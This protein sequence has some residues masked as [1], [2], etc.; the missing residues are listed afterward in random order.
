MLFWGRGGHGSPFGAVLILGFVVLLGLDLVRIV[1]LAAPQ[2][3]RGNGS[4]RVAE[5]ISWLRGGD[6]ETR[7]HCARC[8]ECSEESVEVLFYTL[9]MSTGF[10]SDYA[11]C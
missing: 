9:S 3:E 1:W 7:G 6:F 2:L 8:L 10:A 11:Y 5:A 4:G